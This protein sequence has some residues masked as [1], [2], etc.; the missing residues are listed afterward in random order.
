MR[1]LVVFCIFSFLFG[2]FAQEDYFLSPTDK[3]YFLHTVKKS[4]ILERAFGEYVRYKG[5]E[6]LLPNGEINYD[7]IELI[8]IKDPSLVAILSSEISKAPK[9]LLAEA[10]N[11]QAI[12]ELNK[13]LNAFRNDQLDKEGLYGKFH[14]FYSILNQELPRYAIEKGDDSLVIDR[15]ILQIIH[16]NLNF[17]DKSAML[18]NFKKNDLKSKIEIIESINKAIN[19]WVE[20]RAFVLFKKYGGDA[21]T[22]VNVLTAAGDGS[23]TSG[24]FEER[25]KDDLGRWNRGLP[26]AV[27]LFPYTPIIMEK[28]GNK[29][30]TPQRY[31]ETVL[32]TVGDN[33]LT[34]VHLDVWGYN[35]EKQTTVVI[36]KGGKAYPLF[37]SVESRFL[38]PD[39]SFAGDA[40]Y[41][42][43]INRVQEDIRHFEEKITG[44]KGYDSRI[45]YH[46]SRKDAKLLDIEK[47]EKELS[48]LRLSP[49]TT[50]NKKYKTK[51]GKKQRKKRQASL[52]Q[53]YEQ[54]DA[55]KRKIAEY[56]EKKITALY[57]IQIR[58]QQLNHMLDLIGRNWM[59]FSERD[60]LYLFEDSSTFDILT[61]EFQFP[62]TEKPETFE[63]RL[64]AIP[65]SHV[66]DQV[67]EVMLHINLTDAKPDYSAK[68]N[69]LLED[70]FESNEFTFEDQIINA[71]D[72]LALLSFFE[73]LLD[74]EKD[75]RIISRGNGIGIW[76]G[77][78]A[79]RDPEQQ[80]IDTYG[81]DNMM[82]DQSNIRLRVSDIVV[83]VDR[84][85]T[86][87][88]NSYTDPVRTSFSPSAD[89]IK[90]ISKKYQ[91]TGNQI[92][93]AYRSAFILEEFRKELNIYA[94]ELLPRPEAKIVIDR[95]N[96]AISK[97]RVYVAKTSFKLED[98]L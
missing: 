7:S 34:N 49:I 35:S 81:A 74:K 68:L 91:L 96:K 56:E 53:Y 51:S 4:P 63:I 8:I 25:D 40:T 98:L 93:S 59:S 33:K 58:N 71:S 75:L 23:G 29:K 62:A 80:Q 84:N 24:L 97:S 19:L 41:Y 22:F 18:E 16:P 13:T 44:K 30:I 83:K 39:S 26:K 27:G 52:I 95:L 85:I 12:W 61:Q 72:S 15:K 69:I 77:F 32:E 76:N 50:N 60:G 42:S 82:N 89:K 46:E 31:T 67:D 21:D 48:D 45:E 17:N 10:A 88:V 64:I 54:L 73:A 79:I 57:E 94:G 43:M 20:D 28:N 70:V 90:E 9:G 5:P 36:D 6:I 1:I 47:S 78:K 2:S 37:G 3:A 66:S 92:L 11:K 65:Y 87:Y 86:L 55:I 14:S 38:S